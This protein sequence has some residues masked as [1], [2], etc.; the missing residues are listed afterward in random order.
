MLLQDCIDYFKNAFTLPLGASQ[1]HNVL[2]FSQGGGGG[3]YG[4]RGYNIWGKV[5]G[6]CLLLSFLSSTITGYYMYLRK[7]GSKLFKCGHPQYSADV[8]VS[9]YCIC[10]QE[11]F[12]EKTHTSLEQFSGFS[13]R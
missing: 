2:S 7:S 1:I 12:K 6:V 8:T 4:K 10:W 5:Q 9:I 3:V 11:Q 13:I